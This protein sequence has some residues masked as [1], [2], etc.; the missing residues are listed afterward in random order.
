MFK[1][2]AERTSSG[3]IEFQFY[4]KKLFRKK[5]WRDDSLYVDVDD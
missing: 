5:Y 1:T 3:Y 2:N 4:D